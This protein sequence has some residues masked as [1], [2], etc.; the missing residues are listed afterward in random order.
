MISHRRIAIQITEQTVSTASAPRTTSAVRRTSAKGYR[1]AVMPEASMTSETT[2]TVLWST[3]M[4][5][6]STFTT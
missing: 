1:Q 5:P 6:P 4:K 2:V 3:E